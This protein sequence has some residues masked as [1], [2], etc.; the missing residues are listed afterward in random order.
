MRLRDL[1]KPKPVTPAEAK[2]ALNLVGLEVTDLQA[3]VVALTAN[4]VEP[5]EAVFYARQSQRR[6]SSDGA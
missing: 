5:D 6:E 2:K 4:G 3:Q 1:F